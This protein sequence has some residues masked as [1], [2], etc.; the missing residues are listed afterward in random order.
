M[1]K[2]KAIIMVGA[3]GS[4]KGTQGKI[5]QE[6]TGFKAYVMSSLIRDV[7]KPGSELFDKMARG[8]LL[9]DSDV[10][11]I[12][13]TGFGFEERVIIDGIPRSLD[14]AY[15]LYGFLYDNNYDVEVVYLRV[16]EGKLLQRILKRAQE[17]G[18]SD[19]NEEVFKHR[20]QVF[21]DSR[22]VVLEVFK[23]E[24]IEVDGDRD[25]DVI[26]ND[27]IDKLKERRV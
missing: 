21:D 27:I 13:R 9:S 5:L 4:G 24:I 8:V 22:D 15:W 14:Q 7:V 20:L 3:P 1:D 2:K 25:I 16:D 26:S 11:E 6:R 17:Q 18:R 12:F 19:D 23:K 10:F